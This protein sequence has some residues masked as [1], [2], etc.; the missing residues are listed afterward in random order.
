MTKDQTI[1]KFRLYADDMSELSS[2]E[3]SDLY[4]KIYQKVWSDRAWLFTRTQGSGNT[5]VS[6]PDVSLPADFRAMASNKTGAEASDY[7]E[8]P[9]VF[10]GTDLKEYR[11]VNFENRRAYRDQDGWL[12]VDVAG[13]KLV[14]TRQPTAV[15][16]V[17]F[18]YIKAAPALTGS[19]SP[20]WPE[21]YHH[22]IY[23]GMLVDH[24]IIRQSDKAKSYQGENFAQYEDYI[25]RMALW[26]ANLYQTP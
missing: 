7:G 9:V 14:F 26:N 11:V 12:Y 25:G 17:E 18:D 10:V 16:P 15:M 19:Q 1:A 3:E 21:E 20:V 24:D 5:S 6:S 2:Q 23:H 22:V 4:D 13:N 8:A